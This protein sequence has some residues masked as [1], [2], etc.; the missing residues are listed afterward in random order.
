MTG[1]IAGTPTVSG[2]FMA[3]ISATNAGGTGSATLTSP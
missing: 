3:N 1:A 2:T